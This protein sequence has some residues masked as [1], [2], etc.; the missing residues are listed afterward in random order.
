MANRV[1]HKAKQGER[2]IELKVCF[3]TYG[4]ANK[5]QIWP[6]H[7]WTRG[8][9]RIVRNDAHGIKPTRGYKFNSLMEIPSAIEKVLVEHGIELHL[10]SK[11]DRYVKPG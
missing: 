9:V 4:F 3:W 11:M 1:Y 7:A 5:G 6:K 8:E 10:C 2:M